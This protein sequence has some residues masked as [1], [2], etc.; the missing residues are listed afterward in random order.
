MGLH[1]LR[2][3]PVDTARR[4]RLS[5]FSKFRQISL[6]P[7]AMIDTSP[8]VR[9]PSTYRNFVKFPFAPFWIRHR[10]TY[11]SGFR[12]TVGRNHRFSYP[13]FFF[14][15]P[16]LSRHFRQPLPTIY[17]AVL[18]LFLRIRNTFCLPVSSFVVLL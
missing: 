12:L 17:V 8:A 15:S 10:S 5:S 2:L 14:L 11:L 1:L 9:L 16:L 6:F 13:P 18:I 7:R 3:F 4:L